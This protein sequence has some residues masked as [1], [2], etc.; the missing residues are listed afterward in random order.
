MKPTCYSRLLL[1]LLLATALWAKA[2]PSV[3]F[4][5]GDDISAPFL[6][7]YD[8]VV[9]DPD[10]IDPIWT[11]RYPRKLFAYVSV[12]EYEAWRH[13]KA[14]REGWTQGHNEAWNSDVVDYTDPSY[15]TFLLKHLTQLRHRG[16]RNFFFDT[17]DAP[18]GK[19]ATPE[20]KAR[21]QQALS[22][23]LESIR[24][25]FPKARIIANRGIEVMP[26]LCRTVDAFAIES[27]YKGIDAKTK[28]YIE[29]SPEDRT[30]VTAQLEKAKACGLQPIVIDYL[31]ESATQARLEDAKTIAA[32]GYTP[33]VTDRYL[34]HYGEGELPRI[35]RE[36]LLLYDSTQLKDGDKVYANTHLMASMP[37]EYLGYIPVMKDMSRGLP[38]G[39]VDRYS[40]VIVW[41][42]SYA[43]DQQR[44]FSWVKALIQSGQK[45]LF[46]NDFGFEMTASRANALGLI[47]KETPPPKKLFAPL[48]WRDPICNSEIPPLVTAEERLIDAPGAE[49]LLRARS[50]DGITFTPA[51]I[52]PWGGYAVCGS[53]EHDISG[54]P[55]WSIDPFALFTRALRLKPIPVPD[56]TTENGRRIL[57]I[58]ID[59]DGFIEKVRFNPKMYAGKMLEREILQKYPLPHS[60]SI[61]EGEIGPKGLYPKLSP[62]MERDARAIF[63]LPY[64]EIASHSYSHPFKWQKVESHQKAEGDEGA[65]HL[66]IPGYD[67]NLSREILGSVRYIDT[68]LAPKGKRCRLFFWTG[69][70]LPREDALRMCETH[71][72]GAI[73]GGDTTVTR[74][75]PWLGRIA[76]FGLQ[77]GPFWQI[78]VGEQNE[79]IYTNDWLGPYWGY[80]KVLETF[81]ITDKPK[82]L[83][84]I[85]IY[86][87]FY[88]A[89]KRPSLDALKRAYDYAVRQ[90]PIPL[91][92]SDY[93][94]IVH[95][96][97][98][99]AI[100]RSG[101]GWLIRNRGDLR[102]LR[103]PESLGYPDMLRSR[104]IVG[105][106]QEKGFCYIHLDGRKKVLLKT[107]PRPGNYP[108]LIESNGRV[109]AF[110]R[111]AGSYRL[112]LKAHQP[113][114]ARLAL[115][116]GWRVESVSSGTKRHLDGHALTIQSPEREAEVLLVQP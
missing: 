86:Y 82:R 108:H 76:P 5:Y 99:T 57:F 72:L 1:L 24:R 84:P 55:M 79:N 50:D 102:T 43:K 13:G 115:P 68:R 64:V 62:Q 33:W 96:F 107:R 61:I 27:L 4:C 111:D 93:I 14:A 58:H 16:Y 74:D 3:A 105:Y 60:V 70:C 113:L 87:H 23:L 29:V 63:R 19:S 66:P 78:Y 10:R 12:G 47:R 71:R 39:G 7:S 20:A 77:R 2:H 65:Y 32:A 11:K 106:R 44:F 51:A 21:Q 6:E 104:G 110:E 45:V 69:D 109:T 92:T 36:V 103:L 112:K 81:A 41:P 56:P 37:L 35:R 114:V 48:T 42:G 25:R 8:R 59:G 31:P 80:R 91:F 26:T 89:S 46:L 40:G 101:A 94:A 28:A 18:F 116:D 53:A 9:V 38:W 97:Y 75:N 30:W 17:L 22:Q 34:R 52:T 95:D 90:H 83:K 98:R 85:D 100:L 49:A 73:N 67:F 88:S 15:R 54:E